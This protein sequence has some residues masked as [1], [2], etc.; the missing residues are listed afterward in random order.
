MARLQQLDQ[1][2]PIYSVKLS[3]ASDKLN[4][5]SKDGQDV[6]AH[7]IAAMKLAQTAQKDMDWRKALSDPKHRQ[8]DNYQS[9]EG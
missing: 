5:A 1:S 3:K 7:L 2:M 9:I 8:N 6:H 4:A